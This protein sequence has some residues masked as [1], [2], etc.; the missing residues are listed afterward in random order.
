M[1]LDTTLSINSNCIHIQ[2]QLIVV[3]GDSKLG[4]IGIQIM[5]SSGGNKSHRLLLYPRI[6]K[7]TPFE[8]TLVIRH[9]KIDLI[10]KIR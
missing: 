5:N 7:I 4:E 3:H 6:D 9:H 2:I 10:D 8:K 1:P